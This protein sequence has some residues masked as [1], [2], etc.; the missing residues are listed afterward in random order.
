MSNKVIFEEGNYEK[1]KRKDE[2]LP[3]YF[4]YMKNCNC[5]NHKT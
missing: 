4:N 1:G 2:T 5:F 3:T